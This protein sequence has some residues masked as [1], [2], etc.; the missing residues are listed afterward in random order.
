MNSVKGKGQARILMLAPY[1]LQQA[2]PEAIVSAKFA[3]ALLRAGYDLDVLSAE[4]D[5]R[6]PLYP[7]RCAESDDE[8][9]RV[10]HSIR[11]PGRWTIQNVLLTFDAFLE[12]GYL[13]K[14]CGWVGCAARKAAA[15]Q[16]ERRYDVVISRNIPSE[17]VGLE[18]AKK[19]GARWI[20]T[21]NDPY[22]RERYP[23]PYGNGRTAKLSASRER[24]LKEIVSFA[25]WHLFPCERLRDYMLSYMAGEVG[26]KSSIIPHLVDESAAPCPRQSEER[27]MTIVH[28]GALQ[29]PRGP[30]QFIK[31]LSLF[32]QHEAVDPSMIRV[33]FIGLVPRNMQRMLKDYSVAGYCELHGGADYAAANRRISCADATLLI[34]AD[35]DD[36][37]FLPSKLVEYVQCGRP[38]IAIGPRKGT[39]NDLITQCGGGVFADCRSPAA[40]E[41]SLRVIYRSWRAGR[42][43][44][45]Y[46]VGKLK[47]CFTEKRAMATFAEILNAVRAAG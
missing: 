12:T 47:D 38:T 11:M 22:P 45:D 13:F 25:A 15:L 21:W 3:R 23:V 16:R 30:E 8:L 41:K 17:I 6:T 20:V 39:V 26:K 10:C 2:Q 31:G 14:G 1:C 35:L 19:S 32:V 18:L 29:P 34:E 46:A 7:P 27:C 42:L 40:I 4:S 44:E 33:H 36:G 43:A 28:A 37:I 9:V 24:L 5:N